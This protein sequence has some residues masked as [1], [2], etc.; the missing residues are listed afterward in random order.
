MAQKNSDLKEIAPGIYEGTSPAKGE[1]RR[2]IK[3]PKGLDRSEMVA[4]LEA[5]L[6]FDS[7]KNPGDATRHWFFDITEKKE[8]IGGEIY[9]RCLETADV[10]DL[11]QGLKDFN[12][13]L[14]EYRAAHSEG[15]R[16]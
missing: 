11:E 6:G 15:S 16:K 14:K 2:F 4:G 8:E 12:N 1:V 5:I 3:L 7:R 13:R 10:L 9:F